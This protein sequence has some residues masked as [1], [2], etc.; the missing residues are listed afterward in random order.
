MIPVI[1]IFS[2]PGGLAEGFSSITES[3]ERK[4]DIRLSI[5]CESYAFQT[6]RLRSFFRQF[7][8]GQ[9]PDDYYRF[10][11]GEIPLSQLYSLW[12][13][14]YASAERE[15]LQVVLGP[16]NHEQIDGHI[17]QALRQNENWILIGGP[18]C[19]A[20][21][22]AGMVGNRT[23]K[24]YKAEND[25]RYY[26]YQEYI[27]ILAV[28]A[29]IAFVLENVPG[30]LAARLRGKPIITNVIKGLTQPTTAM[31][32]AF[33]VDVDAPAYRLYSLSS[34]AMEP[35]DNPRKF[36]IKGELHGLPQT[37]HRI[38]II[39]IREDVAPDDI[40]RLQTVSE[41]TP[42]RAVLEGLPIIR[43]SLSN[44]DSLER[45]RATF[46]TEQTRWLNPIQNLHGTRLYRRMQAAANRLAARSPVSPGMEFMPG[47]F[48]TAWQQDW[49]MDEELG[50][51]LHHTAR[52]HMQSDLLRYLF[53]IC[54]TELNG[55]FPRLKDYPEE[56]LP[57]HRNA[58]TGDF[59]DRFRTVLPSEPAGTIISHMAKDGHA[60][61]HPDSRQCRSLTPREAARLQTF[62][63]N[64]YFAG[65]RAAQF[66]QIGNAVPPQLAYLVG[67]ILFNSVTLPQIHQP[68]P[69][70][71]IPIPY[72]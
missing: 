65:G 55:N 57:A 8:V 33:G 46:E 62:P 1:D 44:A 49:Y 50:G 58:K 48:P 64:Y 72:A 30:M 29:P 19:Q 43:S 45:W 54:Y 36:L 71:V 11:R 34:G 15:T 18:P 13:E 23:R 67:T 38:I 17:R 2:G 28:H 51:C 63:D 42:A 9:V 39:G 60:F 35:E 70:S 20:Y 22:N 66:R 40:G 37:R 61:I 14:A 53:S 32:S 26:L 3:G 4:F 12:G 56:L 21:S 16:G 47:R 69:C 10:V 41:C 27:R 7:P 24:G 59:K 52:P 25:E 31:K 5:E 6:L 68:K